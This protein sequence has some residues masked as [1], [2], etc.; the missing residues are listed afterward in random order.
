ME[1]IACIICLLLSLIVSRIS[2]LASRAGLVSH[3]NSL[4]LILD[5]ISSWAWFICIVWFFLRY[6]W[7]IGGISIIVAFGIPIF[8]PR[9]TESNAFIF[10]NQTV[11]NF[12]IF[13][14]LL[15]TWNKFLIH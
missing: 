2:L 12:I 13:I 5:L 8:F 10:H 15:I 3:K 14:T 1:L 9:I 11:I 4:S 6:G 7:L